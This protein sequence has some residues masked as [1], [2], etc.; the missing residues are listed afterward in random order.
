MADEICHEYRASCSR[1]AAYFLIRL[2]A[3]CYTGRQIYLAFSIGLHY[4]K[5]VWK[6]KDKAIAS[7][8]KNGIVRARK[9]GKTK[10]SVKYR[11]R[12]YRPAMPAGRIPY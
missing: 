12:A 4:G 5:A 6:S 1:K 11:K 10:I 9:S 2:C 7:V 3:S 8:D